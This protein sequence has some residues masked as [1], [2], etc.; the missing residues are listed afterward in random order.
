MLFKYKM[1]EKV[2]QGYVWEQP[3]WRPLVSYHNHLWAEWYSFAG[4]VLTAMALW[5]Y[6]LGDAV[7]SMRELSRALR[8]M[9][10]VCK[11]AVSIP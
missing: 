5:L 4:R 10:R 3:S 8:R 1:W 7:T 2:L 6:P 9:N 11:N